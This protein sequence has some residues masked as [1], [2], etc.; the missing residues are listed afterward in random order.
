MGVHEPSRAKTGY[1][2]I[3]RRVVE[4]TVWIYADS[5]KDARRILGDG[6]SVDE[7]D[8][9]RTLSL[10]LKRCPSEDVAQDGSSPPHNPVQEG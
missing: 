8:D 3:R 5:L 7:T 9:E 10:T 6:R 1:A 4:Q 2:F